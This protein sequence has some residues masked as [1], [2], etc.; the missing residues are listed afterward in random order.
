M[1]SNKETPPWEKK[2]WEL[3]EMQMLKSCQVPN[4][5]SDPFTA[6]IV[7]GITNALNG[8]KAALKLDYD[9]NEETDPPLDL[10]LRKEQIEVL[11]ECLHADD[12]EYGL[13]EDSFK[14]LRYLQLICN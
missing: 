12:V 8:L 5:S 10:R 1:T 3:M 13:D 11:I 6:G 7:E 2:H 9:S 4:V 14:L